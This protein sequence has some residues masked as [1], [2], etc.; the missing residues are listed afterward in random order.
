MIEQY[1]YEK[2]IH[3][4]HNK[5]HRIL[6]EVRLVKEEHRKKN[7]RKWVRFERD[8][9]N[10]MWQFDGTE[11]DDEEWILPVED[12]CSRYCVILRKFENMTTA[13][14]IAI[15]EEAIDMYGKPKEILTDNGP[16]FGGV[17]KDSDFDKW[18]EKQGII[19][20]RSGVHKPTTLGKISAIQRTIQ[21]ELPHWKGDTELWRMMY[22]HE[23]P[24]ESLRGL[25]PAEVYFQFK[26]HKK[27]YEL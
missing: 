5:I 10:S 1:L 14:V 26:R 22:N 20:I 12:D 15:L 11:M 17:S 6:L 27:H 19:H 23:R 4:S 16:E 8:N 25:T 9:S 13:N 3:I 7:R 2:G 24:H 21:E 18:C